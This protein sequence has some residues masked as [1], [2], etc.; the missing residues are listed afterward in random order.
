MSGADHLR[1]YQY[2]ATLAPLG[3]HQ[4]NQCGRRHRLG[5]RQSIT[6]YGRVPAQRRPGLIWTTIIAA[7]PVLKLPGLRLD[8]SAATNRSER[9]VVLSEASLSAGRAAGRPLGP[10]Q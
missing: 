4:Q 1:A 5:S 6:V 7:L 2:A 8:S 9:A 10:R 3:K